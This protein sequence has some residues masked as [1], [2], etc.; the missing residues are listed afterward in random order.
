MVPRSDRLLGGQGEGGVLADVE[1]G[2]P[3]LVVHGNAGVGGAGRRQREP[4]QHVHRLC[5]RTRN[6]QLCHIT[7]TADRLDKVLPMDWKYE[8]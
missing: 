1:R 3:G 8:Q 6:T 5:G 4:R 7:H 2:T